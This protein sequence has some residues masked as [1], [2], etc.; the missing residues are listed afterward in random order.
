M[1][2]GS[3]NYI[4]HHLFTESVSGGMHSPTETVQDQFTGCMELLSPPCEVGWW[5]ACSLVQHFHG[6]N[7]RLLTTSMEVGVGAQ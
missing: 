3:N 7:Y 5:F 6:Y 2:G 1:R 4:L